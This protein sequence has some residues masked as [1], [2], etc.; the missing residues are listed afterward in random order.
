MELAGSIHRE[1]N[2]NPYFTGEILQ[3][4]VENG[5]LAQDAD[6][7]WHTTRALTGSDIPAS[8]MEVIDHRVA[9][10]GDSVRRVLSAAA[11]LGRDVDISVL[12]LVCDVPIEELL[13]ALDRARNARLLVD[14]PGRAG[15]LTFTH[16]LVEYA[17]YAD[18]NSLRRRHLHHRVA[19]TL[20]RMY[21][22]DPGDRIGELAFHWLQAADAA[23]TTTAI[24]YARRAGDHALTLLAPDEAV[25][26]FTQALDLAV[27]TPGISRTTVC[28]LTIR[29][30][31]A[32]RQAGDPDYRETLLSGSAIAAEIA[33][34]QL[35][36]KAALLNHRGYF[37]ATGMVDQERVDAIE[38]ALEALGPCEES[39]E[40]ARL[41]SLLVVEQIYGKPIVERRA[42]SDEA[43]GIA[44]RLGDP[45]TTAEVLFRRLI[46]DV[47]PDSLPGRIVLADELT[48]AAGETSDP[49]VAYWAATMSG[50]VALQA[51]D[52]PAY[53]QHRRVHS[54]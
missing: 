16:A 39:A 20:D 13:D 9:R 53:R 12:E 23:N 26:W 6:G 38:A 18:L 31:D 33:D 14:A 48:V 40:R 51:I 5:T 52:L 54:V 43:I 11:V 2:G 21:G 19:T 17:V 36:A 28:E 42:I 15:Y 45:S 25:R 24:S 7:R 35:L 30:G 46:S 8:V 34:P 10:L 3:H 44:R 37:T 49:V 27:A 41:L 47:L 32:K 4:L 1:T 22:K 50:V 29:L